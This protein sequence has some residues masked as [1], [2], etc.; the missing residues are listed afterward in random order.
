MSSPFVWLKTCI[1]FTRELPSELILTQLDP[2]RIMKL[3]SLN[4][5]LKYYLPFFTEVSKLSLPS[6]VPIKFLYAF[7]ISCTCVTCVAYLILHVL[8]TLTI[9]DEST[10]YGNPRYVIFSSLME[11]HLYV[12][13]LSSE[14]FSKIG[15]LGFDYRRGLGIF[16][17]TTASRTALRPTQPPVQW[18]LGALSLG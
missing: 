2:A 14:I 1:V 3:Y 18:V 13:V 9:F 15:V 5:S 17:F 16:L 4:I 11:R 12:Q 8:I 7:L 6:G 10:N